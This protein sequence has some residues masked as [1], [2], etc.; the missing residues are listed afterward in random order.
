MPGPLGVGGG[1]S[2]GVA[3]D[4]DF[5]ELA[6]SLVVRAVPAKLRYARESAR[7]QSVKVNKPRK[8]KRPDWESG[9]FVIN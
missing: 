5:V 6:E 4:D 3:A 2:V 1:V 8:V 9:F 7:K